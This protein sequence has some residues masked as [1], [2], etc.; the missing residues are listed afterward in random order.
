MIQDF[1]CSTF[2]A[3]TLATVAAAEG[4]NVTVDGIRNDNGNIVILV[5]DDA[6]AF[7]TLDAWS[8]IDY[9]QV[10]SRKGSVSHAFTN[11]NAGPYAVLSFH[12]EN[13]DENLNMT[14]TQLLEGVGSTGAPNPQDE[15]DFKA[16]YVWPGDVRVRLHYGQ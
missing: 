16:A 15:P 9:A 10:P 1:V 8:A 3:L 14:A 5:F 11:L 4:L 7:D 13:R 2:V 6:Q 12:D